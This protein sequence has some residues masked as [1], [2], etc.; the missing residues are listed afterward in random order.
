MRI[1]FRIQAALLLTS[2]SSAAQVQDVGT[3]PVPGLTTVSAIVDVS[4]DGQVAVGY[5]RA[6]PDD[7]QAIVWTE[8]SGFTQLDDPPP[9]FSPYSL[10]DILISGDGSVAVGTARSGS[11]ANRFSLRWDI[12][13]GAVVPIA[14]MTN[15]YAISDDG[16]RI[17]G[18]VES[19]SG[20]R[21]AVRWSLAGGLQ[22]LGG[23]VADRTRATNMSG[24][25]SVI[26]GTMR[27]PG[28]PTVPFRWTQATGLNQLSGFVDIASD[29]RVSRD[30]QV[31]VGVARQGSFSPLYAFRWTAAGG[32]VDLGN[33]AGGFI[34]G[35]PPLLVSHDGSVIAGF[36]T[37]GQQ[38]SDVGWRW[39]QSTGMTPL[40][41]IPEVIPRAMSDDGTVIACSEQ[42]GAGLRPARWTLS[43]GL[44]LLDTFNPSLPGGLHFSNVI[45]ADGG[46]IMGFSEVA[47]SEQHGA[48]W[49]EDGSLGQRICSPGVPNS[50]GASSEL[51][52]AGTNN[53]AS[54][55]LTIEA[56]SLPPGAFGFV[57]C[58]RTE[59]FIANPGGSQGNLCLSGSIGRYVGPGQI[60]SASV[61]GEF[62]LTIDPATLIQPSGPVAPTYGE[63]WFF[64]AWHRD[65]N[66]MPTSNFTNAATVRLY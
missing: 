30:G 19:P 32:P 36:E 44:T 26:V 40:T 4:D 38:S 7:A 56:S 15:A 22:D 52:L 48:L 47:Q 14:E 49:R 63:S 16:S 18:E 17:A 31:I 25:G 42:A 8:D 29:V 24:D 51:R 1:S 3:I 21:R 45:S 53:V 23:P 41:S 5:S 9:P 6:D 28:G 12:A 13:S 46:V 55:A 39:T 60:Q 11:G 34:S 20:V 58:S 54:G 35:F 65:A 2:T 43:D 61:A 62:S 33:M 64:Q 66:P 59:G 10:A 57:V 27:P 37:F 50:T